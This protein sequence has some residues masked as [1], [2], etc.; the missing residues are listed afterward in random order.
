MSTLGVFISANSISD[1]VY[2]EQVLRLAEEICNKN[3][4]LAYGGASIGLMGALADKVLSLGGDVTGVMPEILVKK[5][6]THKTLTKAI[7]VKSMRERKKLLMDISD[8]FLIF[9]GGLGTLEELFEVWNAVKIG[10]I[11]KKIGLLNINGYFDALLRFIDQ[12]IEQGFIT[13]SQRN[14][15]DVSEDVSTLLNSIY[16]KG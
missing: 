6:I 9:P 1:T 16:L 4:H 2:H 13:Q 7:I 12:A 8:S 3:I 10:A 15:I 14:L 11:N 5:E